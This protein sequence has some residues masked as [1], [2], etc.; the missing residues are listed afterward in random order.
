MT[1]FSLE[2]VA[3]GIIEFPVQESI[4]RYILEG[5]GYARV[6][7]GYDKV[8]DD[9]M[10]ATVTTQRLLI[11]KVAYFLLHGRKLKKKPKYHSIYAV[12]S[13]FLVQNNKIIQTIRCYMTRPFD[14]T[15]T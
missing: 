13:Y 10:V 11:N 5:C 14:H 12:K 15:P 7:D 3:D 2:R 6:I 8:R 9:R 4:G 1:V